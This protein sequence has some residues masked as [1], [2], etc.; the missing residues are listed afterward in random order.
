VTGYNLVEVKNM[1]DSRGLMSAES[2]EN[3]FN[4]APA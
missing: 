4:K 2:F 1:L 3:L